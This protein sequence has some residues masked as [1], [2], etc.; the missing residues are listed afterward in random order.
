VRV[1]F[2]E[3][4]NFRKIRRTNIRKL[5][6]VVRS[7]LKRAP[8]SLVP[9]TYYTSPTTAIS[10]TCLASPCHILYKS[11]M[12]ISKNLFGSSLTLVLEVLVYNIRGP[13]WLVPDT[14]STSPSM[15]ISENLF[16][17][18]LTRIIQ[19]LLRPFP[20]PFWLVP[21]TYSTSPCVSIT[22]DPFDSSLPRILHVLVLPFQGTCLAR[23]WT[24]WTRSCGC[25]LDAVSRTCC[26]L[27]PAS[28][29]PSTYWP[30]DA[31]MRSPNS[32]ISLGKHSTLVYTLYL[33]YILYTHMYI[34]T[35]LF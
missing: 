19:V 28:S 17:S 21:V 15:T 4:V 14:Y 3:T 25:R 11:S 26:I 31:W 35:L 32:G 9:D 10:G 8:V 6:T 2:I 20:G 34:F 24:S 12:T 30:R 5:R 1:F 23:P 22:V 16:C 7:I 29:P 18:S 13:V 27:H 33:P